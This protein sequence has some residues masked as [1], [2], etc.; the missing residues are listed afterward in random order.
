RRRPALQRAGRR[1]HPAGR[2][3]GR[4][5][6]IRRG[7]EVTSGEGRPSL[8]TAGRKTRRRQPQVLIITGLSG[9]GKTHVARALEDIGWFCVDNLP[10]ALIPRFAELIQGSPELQRSALVVYM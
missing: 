8:T 7:R 4:A 10:T 6:A 1:A 5:G 9:S 3:Q 2:R